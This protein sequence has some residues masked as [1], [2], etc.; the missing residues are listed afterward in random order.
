MAAADRMGRG[1]GD[2]KK[3][4]KRIQMD[5][6]SQKVAILRILIKK[7]SN[8]EWQFLKKGGKLDPSIGTIK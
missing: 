6:I 5:R 2:R 1:K 4:D 8:R 7:G 3:R